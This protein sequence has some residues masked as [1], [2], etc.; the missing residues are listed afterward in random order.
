[1]GNLKKETLELLELNNKT[2][3]DVLWC[4][5][6][7]FGWFTF[8]DFMEIA[9][10][11]YDS[12]FGGQEV[13]KDLLIV[14]DNW[15]LERHEYDGSEWWEFKTIPTKPERY[16]V[17]KTVCNGEGWETLE[18]MQTNQIINGLSIIDNDIYVER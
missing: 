9:P 14:G 11:S 1:M 8:A 7:D 10:D 13:A 16:N 6:E 18:N 17:P 3:E 2:P 4:G 5:S 12:G 15:W